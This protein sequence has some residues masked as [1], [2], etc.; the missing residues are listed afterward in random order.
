MKCLWYI[1]SNGLLVDERPN[2][3]RLNEEVAIIGKAKL[4]TGACK[5]RGDFIYLDEIEG[6]KEWRL[7]DTE[8]PNCAHLTVA[9]LG[10]DLRKPAF[11]VAVFVELNY[12][13]MNPTVLAGRN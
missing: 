7:P 12:T 5:A 11:I 8:D 1:D 9:R 4:K 13:G 2:E 3:V 6:V 10:N